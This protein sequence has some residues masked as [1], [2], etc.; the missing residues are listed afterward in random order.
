MVA[1]VAVVVVEVGAIRMI[2][3]AAVAVAA[4]ANLR[5][6][7]LLLHPVKHFLIL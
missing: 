7:H 3:A 5:V 1:A 6:I 4:Q 2:L